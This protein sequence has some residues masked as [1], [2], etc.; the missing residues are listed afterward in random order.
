MNKDKR[1][2]FLAGLLTAV[3]VM[4]LG[5][6]A[7]A[8]GRTIQVEDGVAVTINGVPF[9]PRDVNGKEVPLF[10]YNGTTYAPVRAFSKA[11]GLQ[12][13]YDGK[14]RTARIETADYAAQWDPKASDYI[15]GEKAK[16]LALQDAGVKAADALFLKAGLDWE[17]GKAI[18]EVEFCAGQTEYDYELDALTGAILN[19]D[20]DLDDFDWDHHDDYHIHGDHDNDDDHDD[21]HDHTAPTDLISSD[22]AKAEALKKLPGGT[23]KECELD[24][25]DDTGRWEYELELVKDG[26]E[27]DCKV[28]AHTGG[29]LEFK[30]D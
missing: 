3:L 22:Q 26:L 15:G 6:T 28:D 7:L 25:D 30:A 13:D 29:V 1:Q 27:Y 16:T 9:T 18:Y 14:T 17:N 23:V 11:A 12:V 10:A 4:G 21:D 2:G 24:L 5:G 19:R 8:A 20:W